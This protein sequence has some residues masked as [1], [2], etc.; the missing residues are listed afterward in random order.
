M[1]VSRTKSQIAHSARGRVLYGE[2]ANV[3]NYARFILDLTRILSEKLFGH[4]REDILLTGRA[5]LAEWDCFLRDSRTRGMMEHLMK[6]ALVKPD[7]LRD[8]ADALLQLKNGGVKTANDRAVALKL[9]AAYENCADDWYRATLPAVRR[10]FVERYGKSCWPGDFSARRT[11]RAL[12]W[13]AEAKR[14]RPKGAKSE[15][16]KYGWITTQPRKL[17]H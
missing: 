16:K 12:I 9:I 5:T 3:I 14:G 4:D 7:Y 2:K 8:L 6:D 13:L 11:L 1:S 17:K 15:L 10:E